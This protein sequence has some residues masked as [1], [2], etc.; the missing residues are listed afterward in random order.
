MAVKYGVEE[1][2]ID[3]TNVYLYLTIIAA[4]SFFDKRKFLKVCAIMP[5]AT[6]YKDTFT[7]TVL[8]NE[9]DFDAF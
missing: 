2:L 5:D 6:E 3:N 9:A 1:K 4:R 8:C 7:Q